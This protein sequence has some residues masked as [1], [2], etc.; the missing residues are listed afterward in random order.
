MRDLVVPH[1]RMRSAGPFLVLG[2]VGVVAGGLL[3]AVTGPVD[4]EHGSWAAAYLVLVVG[5]AQIVFGTTQAALAVDARDAGGRRRAELA[6]WN[7]GSL[8]V[9]GG[10]FAEATWLVALGSGLLVLALVLFITTVSGASG[11]PRLAVLYRAFAGF[12][13][14]SVAVGTVLSVSR[15]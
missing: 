6:C 4:L 14:V 9:V 7:L 8:L 3:A 15:H 1:D 12:L 10:T 5:V 11:R 2:A 13:A